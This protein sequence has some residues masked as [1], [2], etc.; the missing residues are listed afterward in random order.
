MVKGRGLGRPGWLLLGLVTVVVLSVSGVWNPFPG[1]W[2]WV[3]RSDPIAG[4]G[5]LWQQR[6]GGTPRSVTIAGDAV[7]VEQRTRV[8]AV[9][10]ADGG[11][12]WERKADW[13]AVAGADQDAVVVVGKLLTR[14][15]EVLDPGTGITRRRDSAAVAV[16]TWRNLLLDARCPEPT[17]CTLRAWDPRGTDPL[18]TAH[19]PGVRS[20]LLGDN[21][22]LL[23]TRRMNAVRIDDGVAGPEPVPGL[24]GFPVDGR[25][26]VLDTSTGR[27]LT[28][29]EPDRDE[30]LSVVGGRMLRI[31]ARSK[32]GNCLYTVS[33]WDP[34]TGQEAW[35]RAGVNL[36]TA[37]AVGCL[38]R[39]D[40]LGAR[41]VL[42]GVSPDG[43]E[44]VLDAYDGRLL[45]VTD[46]DTKI[47]AVDDRY[48]LVRA[49]DKRSVAA[50]ELGSGRTRWSRPAEG[51][52]RTALTLPA[53]VFAER[54]PSRLV[55]LDP[56]TG[57]EL[58]NLRTAA[59][60]LA[61]GPHGM[62]IGEGREIG[63]VRF[64]A[65]TGGPAPD[66]DGSQPEPAGGGE[67]PPAQQSC[68]P[69]Q[70]ACSDTK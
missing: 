12:L 18:W 2:D 29:I 58:A 22:D 23:D 34:L 64:G 21:P 32:D 19:L 67:G 68:G 62:I 15:Y 6:V 65:A 5:V 55:A 31:T 69:K 66:G 33:G 63:Y 35:R 25:V 47:V 49:A 45:L 9:R 1:V 26:H 24:L 42:I 60:A 30:R 8:E 51:E 37:D 59:N 56:R 46:P 14:G 7:V 10:L 38:Q 13:S 39:K 57:T 50:R 43:R 11:Q 70:E 3:N 36:G 48:A 28:D 44:A 40:P 41:S 16:W 52:P 53:A 20:G 54:K 17:D 61:V 4:P 27:V